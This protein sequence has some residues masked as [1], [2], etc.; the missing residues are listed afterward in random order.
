MISLWAKYKSVY[1]ITIL[2]FAILDNHCH[3]ILR[4]PTAEHL[5]NFMR[6]VG[7]QIAR[8]VNNLHNRDSAVL[9]D[10]YKSPLIS[11]ESYLKNT[12]QYVWL[13]RQKATG[14][15]ALTDSFCSLSWRL[16]PELIHQL[17]TNDKE[18]VAFSLL[19][20]DDASIYP[21]GLKERR[22][23]LAEL[24]NDVCSMLQRFAEGVFN[25]GHTIGAKIVVE[26]RGALLAAFRRE[27]VR[28][29]GVSTIP[30][31]ELK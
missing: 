19:L 9:R 27:H 31:P 5:G 24:F 1:E 7:S 14:R 16:H 22:R 4:T 13:N 28:I 8:F 21:T 11:T 10:R 25:N 26:F 30:P 17:A 29:A 2:E 15:C 18:R 3:L 20:D 23:F 6:T 12:M